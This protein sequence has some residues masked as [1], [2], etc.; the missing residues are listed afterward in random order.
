[1]NMYEELPFVSDHNFEDFGNI[2]ESPF[3]DPQKIALEFIRFY[4]KYFKHKVGILG[5]SS[6]RGSI[7]IAEFCSQKNTKELATQYFDML[8]KE[9]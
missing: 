6:E 4:E 8:H 1:M 3:Y 9:I 2:K 5:N 7:K